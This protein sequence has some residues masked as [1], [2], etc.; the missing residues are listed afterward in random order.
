MSENAILSEIIKS[1]GEEIK[2]LK[3][4][5]TKLISG[6]FNANTQ[7]ETIDSH[8]TDLYGMHSKPLLQNVDCDNIKPTTRQGDENTKRIEDL[9][10]MILK[11][12]WQLI[13]ITGEDIMNNEY[14]I[15]QGNENEDE[16]NN[17]NYDSDDST[18]THSSMPSLISIDS[19]SSSSYDSK[20][21]NRMLNSS[22]LCGNN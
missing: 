8:L 10:D 17:I 9:E 1:Q 3:I 11:T 14:S 18:S 21:I 22:E 12:R 2:Q 6:L 7:S 15:E 19:N 16:I 5:V 13:S 20:I 4:V